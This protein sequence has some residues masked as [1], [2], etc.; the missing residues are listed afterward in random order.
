MIGSFLSD[1]GKVRYHNEDAGGVFYH[2]NAQML[3]VV[4]DGMGGHKAGDVASQMAVSTLHK[5]WK[6]TSSIDHPE[7]AELWMKDAIHEV[8]MEILKH[9]RENEECRGMGTTVVAALCSKQFTTVGHVGDSRV[10]LAND[11][12]FKRIT[13]DH[14]L[15]NELV[16]SGQISAE[17][18]ETHPRKN[19]LLKAL[20]TDE[21]ISPDI[22]TLE[23]ERDDRL[24]LCSDGLTNKVNEEELSELSNYK[25][26]W[27]E[28][29]QSL[30]NLANDRGGEDNITLAVIHYADS[31][32]KEGVD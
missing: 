26:D 27:Q 12:G 17:Q 23:F 30:I 24:L 10:Y 1:Q 7:K 5:K 21:N 13:E 2:E 19:V 8:N 6:E 22:M 15:V 29:C 9:S 31:S 18:A 14:S 11:D 25:G 3:A 16:R 28:F 20:G 4:A 32:S